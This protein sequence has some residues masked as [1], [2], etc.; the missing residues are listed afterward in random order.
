MNFP[1]DININGTSYEKYIV[2][3][4]FFYIDNKS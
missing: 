2:I 4:S 1:A 3:G